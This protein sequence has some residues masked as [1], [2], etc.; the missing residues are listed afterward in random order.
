VEKNTAF[1]KT[2]ESCN[3]LVIPCTL[4]K[5]WIEQSVKHWSGNDNANNECWGWQ[6]T[7]NVYVFRGFQIFKT[8]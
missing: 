3:R 5:N 8:L 1:Y 6:K 2:V 7:D 4:E